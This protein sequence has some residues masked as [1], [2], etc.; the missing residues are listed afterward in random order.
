V[1]NRELVYAPRAQ[2]DLEG[3]DKRYALQILEDLELLQ[4]PPWPP[5]KVKKLRGQDFWEIKTGDFRTIFWPQGKKVVLLRVVNRR[6]LMDAIDRID[7]R[8]ILRWLKEE[9]GL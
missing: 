4:S 1:D 3:L 2:R 9:H 6:D 7:V 5:G 8:T